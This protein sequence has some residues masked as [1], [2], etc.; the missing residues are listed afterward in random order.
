MAHR[1]LSLVLILLALAG[2]GRKGEL[3]PPGAVHND[4]ATAATTNDPGVQP[5]EPKEKPKPDRP[6]FLDP[7]I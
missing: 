2:C 6:F 5:A 7:L 4:A 3:D 1:V